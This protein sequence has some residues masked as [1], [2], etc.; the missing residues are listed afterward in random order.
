MKKMNPFTPTDLYGMFQIKV[1][2]NY[3][4]LDNLILFVPGETKGCIPF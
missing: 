4:I 2:M 1:Y 3:T